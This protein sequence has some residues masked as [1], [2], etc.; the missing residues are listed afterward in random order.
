MMI[1]SGLVGIYY[2][3]IIAW[4]LHYFFVFCLNPSPATCHGST[5]IMN[6]THN[7]SLLLFR[8]FRVDKILKL[9]ENKMFYGA[10][11]RTL[12]G[13]FMMVAISTMVNLEYVSDLPNFQ[14]GFMVEE[15]PNM[16]VPMIATLLISLLAVSP[17]AVI[18]FMR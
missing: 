15:S 10:I 3:M 6:G 5:A 1:V 11:I 7:V 17:I 13:A 16:A 4:A 18:V 2:N 14:Q 12:L 8:F 9:F